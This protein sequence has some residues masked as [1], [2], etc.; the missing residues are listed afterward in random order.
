MENGYAECIYIEDFEGN[1]LPQ[2]SLGEYWQVR[3]KFKINKP[4]EHFIIGIGLFTSSQ[5]PIWSTWSIAMEIETGK[6]EA[7]FRN[8][9]VLLTA[10]SYSLTLGLSIYEKSFHTIDNAIDLEIVNIKNDA[11]KNNLQLVRTTGSGIILNQAKV[12]INK[13]Y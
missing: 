7:I 5:F 13:Q 4:L 12:I 10:G 1:S 2:I 9:E 8:E 11:V 6:Y 3:I